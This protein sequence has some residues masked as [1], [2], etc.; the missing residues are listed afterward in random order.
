MAPKSKALAK[1][2]AKTRATPQGYVFNEPENP[3]PFVNSDHYIAMLQNL[4]M[5]EMTDVVA[6]SSTDTIETLL[7]ILER[8]VKEF[9]EMKDALKKEKKCRVD[10]DV[11]N[12]S[13]AAAAKAKAK[14]QA[15]H[16]LRDNVMTLTV[17]ANGT[18]YTVQV[19]GKDR[20]GTLRQ[21]MTRQLNINRDTKMTF[22]LNGTTLDGSQ[23]HNLDRNRSSWSSC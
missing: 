2:L 21:E 12:N 20:L 1:S 6:M 10:M 9:T 17:N 11:A 16:N 5:E 4:Q 7:P 22:V 15:L 23:W 8:K 3:T 14:T 19:R 18:A 13:V